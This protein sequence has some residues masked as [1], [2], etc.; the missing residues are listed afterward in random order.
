[1]GLL[2]VIR[3][4]FRHPVQ[5]LITPVFRQVSWGWDEELK[6][7]EMVKHY[8][9]WV[10]V[11]AS[12]NASG[13]AQVPLRLYATSEP[14]HMSMSK[15]YKYLRKGIDTRPVPKM[16][17]KELASREGLVRRVSKAVEVE[18]VVN[19]PFLDL[20]QSINPWHNGFETIELLQTYLDLTGNAYLYCW[21]DPATDIPAELWVLPSQYVQIVPC[22]KNFI[23][24]YLYGTSKMNQVALSPEEVIHFKYPN[25]D[26]LFYGYS[27]IEA[28]W[29]AVQRKEGMDAYDESLIRNN[30]RPD[31]V[32]QAKGRL[33]PDDRK[34]LREQ[35]QQLYGTRRGRGK[36]AVLDNEAIINPI[37]WSPREMGFVQG[38][39][40]TK[41]EIAGVY[42]VPVSKLTTE[43]V[44]RANAE[45]GDY[46]WMKDTIRPRAIRIE[47]KFNEK[48]TPR[49]D[50]RLFVAFDNPVPEDKQYKLNEQ[51]T[52]LRNGVITINE[53]RADIGKPEVPWGESAWMPMNLLPVGIG[54]YEEPAEQPQAPGSPEGPEMEP[55]E[56]ETEVEPKF[57]VNKQG[58]VIPMPPTRRETV[59]MR[60]KMKRVYDE[61]QKITDKKLDRLEAEG[62]TPSLQ[63]LQLPNKQTEKIIDKEMSPPIKRQLLSGG[64]FGMQQVRQQ[65]ERANRRGKQIKQTP[66]FDWD[67]LNPEIAAWLEEYTQH[68]SRVTTKT[69]SDAFNDM[70]KTGFAEGKTIPQLRNDV[71]DFFNRMS[72]YKADMIART[73]SSRAA[74]NGMI[75]AWDK[76]NVVSGERWECQPDCCE[77]CQAIDGKIVNLGN[78]YFQV[79]DGLTGV[80]GGRMNFGYEDVQGP[81]LHPNCR[82]GLTAI[83]KED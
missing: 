10:Y 8:K 62:I 67:V 13:V 77:F 49:F 73:E 17:L 63:I 78:T 11:C 69:T 37:G 4:A 76:S 51:D 65:W 79:G 15:Q 81:P 66:D 29:R 83:L 41:E 2:N 56:I 45:A 24:G 42:G 1:M 28:G 7:Q 80:E 55:E 23:K 33:T 72:R 39:K 52:Y 75:A 70:L 59:I 38:Q 48:L 35:W 16:R 12:K 30:A 61:L 68:F 6:Q 46:S 34:A 53:V 26:D 50:A 60:N 22:E 25:P 54:G 40:M 3:K 5:T 74:H 19:H 9:H 14:Q 44:N 71:H 58:R 21:K 20:I 31:F 43:D 27:P 47:D 64:R 36:P 32:I 82:C 57:I 18:E